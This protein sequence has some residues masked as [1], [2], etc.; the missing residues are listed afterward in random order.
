MQVITGD[1]LQ[2]STGII[3]HGVNCQG[4]MGSGLAL[5]IRKKYPRVYEQYKR[6]CTLRSGEELLGMTQLVR[7]RLEPGHCLVVANMFTQVYYGRSPK[8]KYTSYDAID[9][10]AMDLSRKLKTDKTWKGF[11]TYIP[12][13]GCGLGGGQWSVV[14]E[15]LKYHFSGMDNVTVVIKS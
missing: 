14:H 13:I 7:A 12:Q 9:T 15:I 5:E 4:V 6:F 1:I 8:I 11:P 3:C 10:C 2:Y